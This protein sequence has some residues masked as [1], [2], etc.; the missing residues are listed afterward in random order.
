MPRRSQEEHNVRKITKLGG[1]SSYGVTIPIEMIRALGW[2]EKQ[3]VVVIREGDR[4]I[5]K[6]WKKV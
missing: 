3:K 6:D 5:V 1:G 2:K 4:L